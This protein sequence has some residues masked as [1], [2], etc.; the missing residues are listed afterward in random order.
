MEKLSTGPRVRAR[1]LDVDGNVNIPEEAR[2][3]R[4]RADIAADALAELASDEY[5]GKT[6]AFTVRGNFSSAKIAATLRAETPVPV[7]IA[8]T[9]D[10]Q[11][12]VMTA[13]DGGQSATFGY[14]HEWKIG[15]VN[16]PPRPLHRGRGG[17]L[18]KEAP[19]PRPYS[20]CASG[21]T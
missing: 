20:P 3:P 11:V 19:P 10:G 7:P 9:P 6:I 13:T 16:K 21:A 5:D 2:R 12:K 15:G 14:D 4:A 8:Q 18:R 17:I 1:G